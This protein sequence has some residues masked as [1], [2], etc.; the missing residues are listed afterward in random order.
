MGRPS[1]LTGR[2]TIS[3]GFCGLRAS[4]KMS[5]RR[6]GCDEYILDRVGDPSLAIE[7]MRSREHGPDVTYGLMMMEG[8]VALDATNGS[9]S[10]Y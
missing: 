3:A 9:Q 10:G 5:R 7:S 2:Y 6:D 4:W 8:L 1:L